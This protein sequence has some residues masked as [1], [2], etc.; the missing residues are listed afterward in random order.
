MAAALATGVIRPLFMAQLSF[1]TEVV[2]CWTGVGNL[3]WNSQTFVGV[4]SFAKLG[5]I[6][7]GTDVQ[8]FGTSVTLSGIDPDLLG[9]S[10]TG[11]VPGSQAQLWF[12]LL[13]DAGTIIGSPY[14]L[15]RGTM[16]KVSISAGVDSISITLALETKMLDHSRASNR[17]YTQADQRTR[18][19]TD[20]S[21]AGV[22][23]LNDQAINWGS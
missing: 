7:E 22:E 23:A 2:W 17:R 3:V 21:M 5:T 8:A 9:S 16:D 6:S 12:G 10:M 15:F 13:S 19:P 1:K 18:Y 4:G 20:S 14:Q 11:M